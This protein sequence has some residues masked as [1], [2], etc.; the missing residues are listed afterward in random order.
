MDNSVLLFLIFV[1]FWI[2]RSLYF[3]GV[4]WLLKLGLL[5]L[6]YA[7]PLGI[8]CWFGWLYMYRDMAFISLVFV[9]AAMAVIGLYI[10]QNFYDRLNNPIDRLIKKRVGDDPY[11]DK[12]RK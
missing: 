9:I 11:G 4:F 5:I 10:S 3:E 7:I 8:V 12:K 6:F 1:S 2:I